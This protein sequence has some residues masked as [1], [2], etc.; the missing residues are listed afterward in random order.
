[1]H[2]ALLALAAVAAGVALGAVDL[3]AAARLALPVGQPRELARRVGRRRVAVRCLRRTGAASGAAAGV[4]LLG[5]AVEAYYL[6]ATVF[7]QDDMAVL[8][9][10]TTVL[11]CVFGVVAGVLFGAG[12][13]AVDDARR[14][15]AIL[16][17]AWSRRDDDAAPSDRL[18][19][20][21]PCSRCRLSARSLC[22]A[23]APPRPDRSRG[24]GR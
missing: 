16:D 12:G 1:M 7:Q 10:P 2:P 3:T 17:A 18:S 9:A 5:V 24:A 8:T 6:A 20:S 23:S 13:G 4:V 19:S 21:P 14:S 22:S 11:W 15:D